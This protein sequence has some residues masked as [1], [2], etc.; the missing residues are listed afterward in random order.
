MSR[1]A[2]AVAA[3]LLLPGCT[4]K[5]SGKASTPAWKTYQEETPLQAATESVRAGAVEFRPTKVFLE[6]NKTVFSTSHWV[7]RLRGTVLSPE[8][9]PSQSLSDAFT[10]IGAGGKI[11]A[12]HFST[13]GP[14]RRTWQHQE[15]TGKPTHLPANVP[16][17]IEV[18]VQIGDDK[19]HD[20]VVAF[21]FKSV[22][23][24]LAR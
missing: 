9:L 6:E 5:G 2:I 1:F 24:A 18:F 19:T 4:V 20:E 17:E 12:G 10:F 3:L 8:A 7:V 21:T 23:V 14:G 15:H 22:R 11:Y 13:R 16:G